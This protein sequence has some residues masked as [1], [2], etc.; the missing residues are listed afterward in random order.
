M[1]TTNLRHMQHRAYTKKT[2]EHQ[3]KYKMSTT[4]MSGA[5]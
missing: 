2:C 1:P 3:H 5:Y 4:G